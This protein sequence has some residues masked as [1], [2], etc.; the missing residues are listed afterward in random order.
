MKR[1]LKPAAIEQR[2]L[3][4]PEGAHELMLELG[5]RRVGGRWLLHG[6]GVIQRLRLTHEQVGADS[7]DRGRPLQI[8]RDVAA[9]V[10]SLLDIHA[11]SPGETWDE[12]LP[13]LRMVPEP[14]L[15]IA[16]P[17]VGAAARH[18]LLRVLGWDDLQPLLSVIFAHAV[19]TGVES[20]A[21]RVQDIPDSDDPT[22]GIADRAALLAAIGQANPVHM[23]RCLAALGESSVPFTHTLAYVAAVQG[24]Q[25]KSLETRL[26]THSQIAIKAYGLLPL[27]NERELLQ[28]YLRLQRLDDEAE[29]YEGARVAKVQAAVQVGLANLAQTAGLADALE[30]EWKMEAQL[31]DADE[32]LDDDDEDH[33]RRLRQRFEDMMCR[34]QR[35]AADDVRGLLR[36][37]VVTRLLESLIL[38]LNDRTLG[39]FDAERFA[40]IDLLGVAHTIGGAVQIVHPADLSE[41]GVLAAWQQA[42][43][44]A[45]IEQPFKQAFREL[46]ALTPD[47]RKAKGAACSRFADRMV[48]GDVAHRLLEARNWSYRDAGYVV[49]IKRFPEHG[50]LAAFDFDAEHSLLE[51]PVATCGEI[52]FSRG[53]DLYDELPRGARA[54]RLRDVPAMVFSEVMRDAELVVSVADSERK[55]KR[56]AR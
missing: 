54:L 40:L 44:V 18:A 19:P 50:L 3:E 20:P 22:L 5:S 14:F 25:R 10:R 33:E 51:E 31:A 53:R 49:A 30:L 29:Q 16:L 4:L 45:R 13:K 17:Y 39:V 11:L 46:Y 36:S 41:A 12:L 24:L 43:T 15:L 26:K 9:C 56:G 27:L 28:R 55:T 7:R 34:G 47:E 32:E 1:R 52:A 37:A 8:Q 48:R 2:V 21:H 42:I 38:Q 35:L 23:S 6:L